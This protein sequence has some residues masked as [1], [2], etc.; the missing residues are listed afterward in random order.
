MQLLLVPIF[1]GHK[2]HGLCE[3]KIA[4]INGTAM[5]DLVKYARLFIYVYVCNASILII[6]IDIALR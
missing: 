4:N 5:R 3:S 1:R 2:I 6:T